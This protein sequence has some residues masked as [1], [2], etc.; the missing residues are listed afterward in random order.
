MNEE[1]L[2]QNEEVETVKE[3]VPDTPEPTPEPVSA[4][5]PN[6]EIE[7]LKAEIARLTAN[8]QPKPEQDP[9][10]LLADLLYS[11]P[12]EYTR[13]LREQAKREAMQEMAPAILP[14]YTAHAAK[15]VAGDNP[16]AQEFAARMISKGANVNDP[17]MAELVRRASANYAQEKT[18]Q[19]VSVRPEGR[20]EPVPVIGSEARQHAEFFASIAG[21]TLT[22]AEIAEALAS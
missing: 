22:D 3:A 11:D 6:P 20:G 14:T 10:E 2:N 17:D 16:H 15:T 8:Q 9:D 21:V 18:P 12:K 5:E 4:P 7:A 13:Q 19:K 1:E